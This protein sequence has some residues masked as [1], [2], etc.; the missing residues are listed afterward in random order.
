MNWAEGITSSAVFASQG[1]VRPTGR[2][3]AQRPFISRGHLAIYPHRF[4]GDVMVDIRSG[5]LA[6]YAAFF[7]VREAIKL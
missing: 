7:R 2:R 4:R 5:V 6:L 1:L 3:R